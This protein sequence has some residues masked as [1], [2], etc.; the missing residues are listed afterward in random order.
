MRPTSSLLQLAVC[1]STLTPL[2]AAWG[3]FWP[4]PDS[5]VVRNVVRQ[6]LPRET[7][8]LKARQDDNSKTE[9]EPTKTGKQVKTTNLNTAKAQ[10]GT[11]EET[12]TD[13]SESGTETGKKKSQ[14][15]G[16]GKNKDK[17]GKTT[18][19][20]F[21]ADVAAGGVSV[22]TPETL[23]LATPLFKIGDYATFGWNYTSLEGTPTA[24]DVLVSMSANAETY[25]LTANMTFET[26]PTYVWDTKKAANDPEAPLGNG[27]YTLII[28]DSDTEISD[29]P[30][31]GYL[32]V[33]KT[34]QFGMYTPQD[35]V[36]YPQWECNV[37]N[38][39]TGLD[40][41][42]IGF[43]VSMSVITVATFTWFVAGLGLQ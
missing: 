7:G 12:A 20:A 41:G 27:M 22:L 3:D 26:N 37:C 8:V 1:L 21:S 31:P 35:Y 14:T 42:A 10:T 15:T 24:I 2:T 32:A 4:E 9:E 34:F 39:A 38:A 19:T 29:A 36:P 18:R 6:E 28:K 40:H 11:D 43:A 25:T 33:Q 16:T 17:D 5:V 13:D 30:E 23:L